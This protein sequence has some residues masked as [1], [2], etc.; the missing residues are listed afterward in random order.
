MNL[1][2][3]L[4]NE[5]IEDLSHLSMES[6]IDR[7]P[8]PHRHLYRALSATLDFFSGSK[9]VA[10]FYNFLV[11][12][13]IY[14][15]FDSWLMNRTMMVTPHILSNLNGEKSVLDVGCGCGT[16]TTF[17]AMQKPLIE[18]TGIDLS[19]DALSKAK[20]RAEKYGLSN[21]N[22]RNGDL[23]DLNSSRKFD[24]VIS[25]FSLFET[26]SYDPFESDESF[27]ESKFSSISSVI[28]E[29]KLI[30]T[31]EPMN[32]NRMNRHLKKIAHRTG[33]RKFLHQEIDYVKYGSNRVALLLIAEK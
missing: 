9:L 5:G 32:V 6:A 1:A 3:Y 18:F 8:L 23:V 4:D 11:Q 33:F 21:V 19:H 13:G 12:G 28:D 25:E 22:Y 14:T 17:Y 27:I 15:S 16:K 20:E 24:A 10:E 26:Q 30:L 29:G 31:T 7:I 2:E